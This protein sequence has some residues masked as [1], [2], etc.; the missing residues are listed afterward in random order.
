VEDKSQFYIEALKLK[1]HPEGGFFREIYKSE[2]M[3]DSQCLPDRYNGSRSF[4]TSIYFLLKGDQ[5]SYFHRL[6][7]DEMW[8]FYDGCAVKIYIIDEKGSL[9]TI[10]LGK[11]LAEGEILQA[12][13]KR[14]CW[15]CAEI[16]DKLSFS[17]T[18]CT[19]S[20]G[21]EFDDFEIGNRDEL[22]AR[23]PRHH[24]LIKKFT[25]GNS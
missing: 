25:A 24:N 12:V 1:P 19:V 22:T 9:S 8:H 6:K 4:S 13:V 2:E 14:N 18:G 16:T 3:I 20:P 23:F 7:S 5:I 17:L 21:F 15:F 11:N 10:L